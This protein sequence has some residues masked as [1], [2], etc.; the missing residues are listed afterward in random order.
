[1]SRPILRDLSD[2]TG[3]RGPTAI[4]VLVLGLAFIVTACAPL[5]TLLSRPILNIGDGRFFAT[6][7][8]ALPTGIAWLS[9]PNEILVS[10]GLSGPLPDRY[11]LYVLTN[12]ASQLTPVQMSDDPTCNGVQRNNARLL[13]DGRVGF[14]QVCLGDRASLDDHLMAYDPRNSQTTQLLPYHIPTASGT[15]DMAPDM[16]RGII[17][18]GDRLFE[19]IDWLEPTVSQ[20]IPVQLA[21]AEWPSWS[22]DGKLIALIGAPNDHGQ[23]GVDRLGLPKNI[24]LMQ[25]SD[26]AL[27]LLV[28][29][30]AE[31]RTPEWSP[32]GRWLLVPMRFEEARLGLWLVDTTSGRTYHLLQTSG[33]VMNVSWSP[34]AKAI[35]VSIDG[36]ADQGRP[37]GQR[38]G[39]YFFQTPNLGKL[40]N[41]VSGS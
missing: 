9:N 27:R 36:W 8:D 41:T 7:D 32:N 3:V 23:T 4:L 21:L 12:S 2:W 13:P 18:H 34:D 5:S 29:G 1:M 33:D 10:L 11:P 35:A 19:K 20:P 26:L 39:L 37:G 15:F 22:P 14:I 38:T 30:V 28:A 16:Q 31:A 40:T 6:P 17:D 24:Y 25:P